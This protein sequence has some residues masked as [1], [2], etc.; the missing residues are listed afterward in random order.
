MRG[1]LSLKLHLARELAIR[2]DLVNRRLTC[3]DLAL[4]D[5]IRRQFL[6][7]HHQ[8]VVGAAEVAQRIQEIVQER[9]T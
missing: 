1:F 6:D 8:P 4:E 3:R 9:L 5:F 2:P 7:R